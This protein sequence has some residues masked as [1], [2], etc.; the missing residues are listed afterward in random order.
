VVGSACSG[1]DDVPEKR[2]EPKGAYAK[3]STGGPRT[4]GEFAVCALV[5]SEE[6][7]VAGQAMSA[8]RMAGVVP[9]AA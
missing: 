2:T 1:S 5:S 6:S 4:D 9:T 3:A 7:A 8:A